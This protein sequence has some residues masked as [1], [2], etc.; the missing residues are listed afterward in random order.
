MFGGGVQLTLESS[1]LGLAE[2]LAVRLSVPACDLL[3]LAFDD[4]P[5]DPERGA[6]RTCGGEG[7]TTAFRELVIRGPDHERQ[8]ET[9]AGGANGKDGPAG[10]SPLLSL[11][12]GLGIE[13]T[14]EENLSGIEVE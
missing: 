11:L 4:E 7:D 2:W 13:P 9:K 6:E 10:E 3:R 5:K 8:T 14:T 1:D 12:S